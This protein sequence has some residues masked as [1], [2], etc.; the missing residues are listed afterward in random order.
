MKSKFKRS[1]FIFLIFFL[2]LKSTKANE[3]FIF[4]VTE[5]EILENGDQINGYKG[6]TA[7]S[8]DGSKIIA[9]NFYYNQ[10]TNILEAIGDVKYVNDIENVTIT[11]D[12]MI[13]FK[14]NENVF[15]VGNSKAYNENNTISALN[16][17]YDKINNKFIAKKKVVITDTKKN[18]S[19]YTDKATYL[20]NE[21]KFF[22]EGKTKALIKKKYIFNSKDVTYLRNT[23][24][25]F[26]E[27]K[28][29]IDDDNGNNYKQFH[30]HDV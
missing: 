7:I 29:I 12:K 26:S 30:F 13:Y 17:E 25:L 3:T 5:I 8:E 16:L 10:L 27:E 20:K 11:A 1:I 4:D 18:T 6:G 19:I 15:T 14:N 2:S 9:E 22:S 21:E 24:E 23:E 28:S